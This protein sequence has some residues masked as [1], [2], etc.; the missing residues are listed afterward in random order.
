MRRSG[1]HVVVTGLMALVIGECHIR[2]NISL[3]LRHSFGLNPSPNPSP[4]CFTHVVVLWL[5]ALS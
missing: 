1:T 3:Q 2:L 5:M 4:N